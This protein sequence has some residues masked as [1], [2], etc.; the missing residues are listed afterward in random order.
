MCYPIVP[1]PMANLVERPAA[2][3]DIRRVRESDE[4]PGRALVVRLMHTTA[5][6]PILEHAQDSER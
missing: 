4:D 2:G 1:L 6:P 3:T 5:T